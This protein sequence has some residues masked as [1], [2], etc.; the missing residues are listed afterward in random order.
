MKT[1]FK[2][3]KT[4]K[5]F[6]KLLKETLTTASVLSKEVPDYSPLLS[7]VA[8]LKQIEIWVES[9]KKPTQ[10]EKERINFGL[11]AVREL[12]SS[13]DTQTQKLC[14]AIYDLNYYFRHNF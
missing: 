5:A 9:K 14:Q 11:I 12:E 4:R 6:L 13:S 3:L 10:E 1:Y 8:Q 7:V 2:P